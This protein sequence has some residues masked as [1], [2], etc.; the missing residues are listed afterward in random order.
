MNNIKNVNLRKKIR[1]RMIDK[2]IKVTQ[3]ANEIGVSV[4]YASNYLTGYIWNEKI[5]KKMAD[6]YEQNKPRRKKKE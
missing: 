5:E 4:A 3:I 1:K 6:W 2:N